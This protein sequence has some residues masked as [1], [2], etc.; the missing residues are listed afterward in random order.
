MAG[1]ASVLEDLSLLS[2]LDRSLLT[3]ERFL[4]LLSGLAVFS[5]MVL[6]VVSVGGRNAFNAPLPGYVDWI[7]QA[8]PLIAFM[9][10]AYVQRD[11]GHIRM[12]LVV[13]KLSGRALWFFELLSVTLILLL[14][15]AL[16]W[17]SWEHFLRAFD[18]NA[19]LWSR[20]SSIDI[21]IP[22]W[23]AKLLAP[24]A[25]AV[26]CLR[27]MLQIWGYGRALVLGLESPVAVP[28]IQD[29][30]AQAAAEAEQL[31]GHDNG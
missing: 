22:I 13:S 28:L 15:M 29:V 19:P 17:G 23:P 12:D 18:F 30:A 5:L 2:R 26:L 21:G 11:G 27:L 31:E 1:Q 3:I 6:A 14:M 24:V 8:M 7:E 25:F 10:I 16:V 20:D 9:G 4:A